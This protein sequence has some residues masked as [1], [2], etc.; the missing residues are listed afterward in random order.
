MK[1]SC[2]FLVLVIKFPLEVE[3]V[4]INPIVRDAASI[5]YRCPCVVIPSTRVN[6]RMDVYGSEMEL[7]EII[8]Y[9]VCRPFSSNSECSI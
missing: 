1:E 7:A 4:R 8:R 2:A 5:I 6:L 3:R 9:G